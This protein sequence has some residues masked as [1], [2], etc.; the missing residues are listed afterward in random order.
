MDMLRHTLKNKPRG[1]FK[2]HP[3]LSVAGPLLLISVFGLVGCGQGSWG[4]GGWGHGSGHF[5]GSP[6]RAEKALT[7]IADDVADELALREDQK[8]AYEAL[9][10]Q[11]KSLARDWLEG[12]QA[13]REALRAEAKKDEPDVDRIGELAKQML[14]QRPADA[15]IEQ[16]IDATVA[17]YHTLDPAQQAEVRAKIASHQRWH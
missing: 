17:Y 8:P 13:A 4:H 16:L 1:F 5:R 7:W 2:R 10:A 3:V 6:E 11:Y 12:T 15:R 9:V 14:R